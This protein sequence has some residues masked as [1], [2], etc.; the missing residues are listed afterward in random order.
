MWVVLVNACLSLHEN[1]GHS[2]PLLL[3][4]VANFY[5]AV[6]REGEGNASASVKW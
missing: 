5:D 6:L 2:L 1:G 4:I 3:L